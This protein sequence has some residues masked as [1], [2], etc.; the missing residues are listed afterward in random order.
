M[1][2]EL[3]YSQPG[4]TAVKSPGSSGDIR[5]VVPGYF[6]YIIL[7]YFI[8]F[9]DSPDDGLHQEKLGS[10]QNSGGA[11]SQPLAEEQGW[12]ELFPHCQ[13]GRTP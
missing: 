7:F 13:Q 5:F 6:I 11:R 12:L 1:E 3:E 8:I 10:D 2:K 4:K 9:Q